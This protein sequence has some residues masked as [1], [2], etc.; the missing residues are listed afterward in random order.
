M[1]QSLNELSRA[2][3]FA[4]ALRNFA[5]RRKGALLCGQRSV[6]PDGQKPLII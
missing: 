4:N 2:L 3:R 1:V 5:C 6:E